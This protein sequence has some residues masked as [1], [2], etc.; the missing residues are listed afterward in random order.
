M[1][2][3]CSSL[4]SCCPIML[5]R[6]CLNDFEMVPVTPTITCIIIIIIIIIRQSRTVWNTDL[7]Q[8][9]LSVLCLNFTKRLRQSIRQHIFQI[10][11][12]HC[13]AEDKL[14]PSASPVGEAVRILVSFQSKYL[15]GCVHCLLS[16]AQILKLKQRSCCSKKANSRAVVTKCTFH[17]FL[18]C[19][20]YSVFHEAGYFALQ[21]AFCVFLHGIRNRAADSRF[22]FLFLLFTL[23]WS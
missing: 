13:G 2:V 1:A 6:C 23:L 20:F 7:L 22:C 18:K 9:L 11:G 10:F 5:L 3:V 21:L 17:A 8:L 15:V 19:L 12:R 14:L 16:S 4:I